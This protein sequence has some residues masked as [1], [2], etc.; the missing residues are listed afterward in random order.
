MDILLFPNSVESFTVE[1][2]CRRSTV[3]RMHFCFI[4]KTW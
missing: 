3:L 4:V 1:V 2:E